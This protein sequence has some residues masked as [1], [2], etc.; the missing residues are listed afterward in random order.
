MSKNTLVGFLLIFLLILGYNYLTSPSQEQI[1]AWKRQQDSL[2]A[3]QEENAKKDSLVKV[4]QAQNASKIAQIKADTTLDPATRDSLIKASQSSE[5]A[6]IMG[7][8]SNAA[9]GQEKTLTLQNE[10][11]QVSFSTRGARIIGAEVLGFQGY[12]HSTADRYDRK[13]VVLLSH[14]QNRFEWI[15]PHQPASRGAVSTADLIFEAEQKDNQITFRAYV[16]EERNRYIEQVYTLKPGTY[17]LDYKVNLVGLSELMPANA[18]EIPLIWQT[19]L[20]KIEKNADYESTVSSVHYKVVDDSPTY[21]NCAANDN[22][23]VEEPLQWVTHGQQFFNTALIAQGNTQFFEGKLA[24]LMTPGQSYLKQ[25]SSD[26]WLPFEG[27]GDA[28]YTFT[29]YLGPNDYK[30][31]SA[32]NVSLERIIPFGWSIFGTIGRYII[33]PIFGFLSG[34]IGSHGLI[35]LILTLIIKLITYPLQ[36]KV[37][38]SGVKMSLLRPEIEKL[39]EKYGNDPQAMQMEQFRLYQLYGVNPLGG[40]LPMLLTMPIWIAL[41]R[42]F[43]ASIEFRQKSFLWAEDLASYD[44]VLDLSFNI[45]F[46]GDHVSLFTALWAISMFAFLYYNN[47]QMDMTA[48]AGGNG[49]VNMQMMKIMQYAFPVIFFFA[50]NSWASGLTAY[51]LFSNLLNIAQ[52]YITKNILINKDKVWAQM[53]EIKKNPPK[54]N[55]FMEQAMKQQ[56]EMRRRQGK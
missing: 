48:A 41:Y 21:C 52:T 9:L 15:I 7:K 43:P 46:Y 35:I 28:S 34:F 13:P 51:M 36:H 11:L 49:A 2:I 26:L 33:R 31:L 18:R 10:K 6:S 55:S 19:K 17:T 22:V 3:V 23:T 53:Q 1:E 38:L 45:P 29:W 16:N 27:K 14:P 40:C 42:F 12:D 56:E 4:Q 24:T 37:A 20:Q 25:L 50:L 32:L 39:R 54:T 44:S 8:F 30:E 47:K 5:L